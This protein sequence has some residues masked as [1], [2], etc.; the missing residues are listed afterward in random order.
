MKNTRFIIFLLWKRTEALLLSVFLNRITNTF[1]KREDKK[2]VKIEFGAERQIPMSGELV[3]KII[4]FCS[5]SIP[6]GYYYLSYATM[7][8]ILIPIATVALLVD[9]GRF[10][11]GWLNKFSPLVSGD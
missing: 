8:Q 3:R 11:I 5:L 6:I 2:H 7:L 1:A 10:Y 4:H 9:Y